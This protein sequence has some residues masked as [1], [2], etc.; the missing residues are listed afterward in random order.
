V[1]RIVRKRKSNFGN[2]PAINKPPQPK[3]GQSGLGIDL[4]R[5]RVHI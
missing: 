4:L 2:S 3:R 1:V 5:Y